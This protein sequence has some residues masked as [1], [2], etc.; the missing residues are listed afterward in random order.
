M[1]CTPMLYA[2]NASVCYPYLAQ[3]KSSCIP[4][5]MNK[6]GVYISSSVSL[7]QSESTASQLKT[8][9]SFLSSQCQAVALPFLCL[10]LFPL[11]D[12]NQTTYLPSMA[13]CISVSTDIC[14]SEWMTAK[15]LVTNLPVCSTLPNTSP[16]NRMWLILYIYGTVS[17]KMA[18]R[19]YI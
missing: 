7:Q 1:K 16:C 14:K 4:S 6:D 17:D 3:Y 8:F 12:E 18:L 15:T 9:Q 19:I 5:L 2:N 11:C 13:E 10:Y